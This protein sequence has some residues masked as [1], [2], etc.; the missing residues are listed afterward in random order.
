MA[1]FHQTTGITPLCLDTEE[2]VATLERLLMTPFEQ[3]YKLSPDGKTYESSWD[4]LDALLARQDPEAEKKREAHA[5]LQRNPND[6]ALQKIFK[7]YSDNSSKFKKIRDIFG[8]HGRYHPNQL[9]GKRCL[10]E[11]GLCQMEAM[12]KLACKISDLQCLQN[13]GQLMMDPFDFIRWRVIKK[14]ASLL[15]MP[16]DTPKPFLRSIVYRLGD[17]CNDVKGKIYEDSV[18]RQAALLSARE[19][20][21]L[22]SYGPRKKFIKGGGRQTHLP[23]RRV[24]RNVQARRP[25]LLSGDVNNGTSEAP[26][27]PARQVEGQRAR[28]NAVPPIYTGINDYRARQ[29]QRL[30]AQRRENDK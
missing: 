1:A 23:F 6:K 5:H 29:Q 3:V 27:V 19:R 18:M 4:S 20:N 16:G 2:D 24:I 9:I 26:R 7:H 8:E 14:A 13:N 15:V 21:L 22:N 17:D 11:Q 10:P 30:Q 25:R 12:Y 28:P